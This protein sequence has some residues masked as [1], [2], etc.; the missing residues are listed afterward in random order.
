MALKKTV[1]KVVAG[2]EGKL[3]AKDAYW[4]IES[5]SGTKTEQF[6]FVSAHSGGR[7]IDE[8]RSKFVPNMDGPNFIRQGYDHLKTLP[9]FA[10]AED[11]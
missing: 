3:S 1:E 5:I 9:E 6:V 4:K 2:F 8:F 7:I 11:C 10:G